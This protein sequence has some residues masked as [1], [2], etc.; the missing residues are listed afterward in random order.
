MTYWSDLCQIYIA[1][2]YGQQRQRLTRAFN[3]L[4]LFVISVLCCLEFLEVDRCLKKDF[5]RLRIT[6]E[7]AR[8]MYDDRQLLFIVCKVQEFK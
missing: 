3:K 8:Y 5:R 7:D 6:T 2:T 1:L 4:R